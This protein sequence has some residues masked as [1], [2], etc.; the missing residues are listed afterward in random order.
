MADLLSYTENVYILSNENTI[1]FFLFA[2]RLKN[3]YLVVKNRLKNVFSIDNIDTLETSKVLIWL[4][5]ISININ[6]S[7]ASH[8]DNHTKLDLNRDKRG[9]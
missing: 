9:S 2:K 7:L 8:A 6:P 3:A 1:L 5:E 4:I